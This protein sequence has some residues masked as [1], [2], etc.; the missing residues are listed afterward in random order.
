[1]NVMKS[2]L[3]KQVFL[4]LFLAC[5]VLL[6]IYVKLLTKPSL[7]SAGAKAGQTATA[8]E[9]T[10]L[11]NNKFPLASVAKAHKL[12]ILNFWESWCGPC[13]MEMPDLQK[14]Y[15]TYKDQGVEMI[16]VYSSSTDASVK[17]VV[18]EE[19][20]TFPMVH[21]HEGAISKSYEV[22]AVPSTFVIGPDLKILRSHE[23]IDVG[24]KAFVEERLNEKDKGK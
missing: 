24:L 9:E 17:Q 20:L 5:F 19:S 1:M 4:Y 21:D 10:T 2:K 18:A 23:G 11:D 3:A 13:K 14:L 16:G 12:V 8:F 7:E 6:H 15:A 22:E